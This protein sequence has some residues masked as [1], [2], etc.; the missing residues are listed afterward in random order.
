M[1]IAGGVAVVTGASSGIGATVATDLARRGATVAAVA[2]RK[3]RLD[4]VV[5][6]CRD[7][8]AASMAVPADISSRAE[9]ERVIREVEDRF[10][11]VDILVNNAGISIH[12]NAARTT[13]DDVERLMA[14]NFFAPV[15]LATA[16]LPHMLERGRGAVINIT[17]VA[18]YVP[19]PG[20]S[21]YG[22]A[23]AALSLWTHGLAV[24]LHDTGVQATVVSP[25]PIDTEIWSLDEELSYAGKLYPPQVVADAV[26]DAVDKGWVHRTVPRRY[27]MVG[28]LY[29]AL[30]R[31]MRWG[32]RRFAATADK[33]LGGTTSDAS[34]ASSPIEPPRA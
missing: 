4:E 27:G 20:E 15:Y 28:V 16:A 31:P 30:G 13:A 19:N 6:Q 26:A 3:D 12:R 29:P 17:S 21:A 22:A 24:D 18:G 7:F 8:A 25:G 34:P 23:K 2:R 32:L 9:C 5:E 11:R 1:E 10:G 14:V 33:K